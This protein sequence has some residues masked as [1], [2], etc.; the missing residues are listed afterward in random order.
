MGKFQ[1]SWSEVKI[2]H[3]LTVPINKKDS[4][5]PAILAAAKRLQEL[6]DEKYRGRVTIVFH[7][8]GVLK[9]IE[10]QRFYMVEEQA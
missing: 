2:E 6:A 3:I 7:P 1:L 10:V 5:S 8:E 4:L 9:G